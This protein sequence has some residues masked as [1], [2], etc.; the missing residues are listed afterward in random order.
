MMDRDDMISYIGQKRKPNIIA[1]FRSLSETSLSLTACVKELD[2][3]TLGNKQSADMTEEENESLGRIV[4][5]IFRCVA[6]IGID[7]ELLRMADEGH[8]PNGTR[9]RR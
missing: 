9:S 8:L 3:I 5:R 1:T 7:T 4:D 6:S 2:T